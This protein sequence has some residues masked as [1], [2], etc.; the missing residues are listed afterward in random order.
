M[1]T[2]KGDY[3]ELINTQKNHVV[4]IWANLK[5]YFTDHINGLDGIDLFIFTFLLDGV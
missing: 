5:M 2:Q 3:P 4:Y 1:Q